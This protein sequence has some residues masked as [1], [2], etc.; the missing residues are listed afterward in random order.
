MSTAD[1]ATAAYVGSHVSI[2]GTIRSQGPSRTTRLLEDCAELEAFER[3]EPL[4]FEFVAETI[5]LIDHLNHDDGVRDE[6]LL[7]E[8]G[9]LD[10]R[11]RHQ[12]HDHDLY[13]IDEREKVEQ[14]CDVVQH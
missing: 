11:M 12:E 14:L 13:L 6:E 9:S 4:M 5:P 1:R 8:A 10:L 7:N 3:R 2:G